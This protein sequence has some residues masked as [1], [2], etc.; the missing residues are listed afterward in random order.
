MSAL[1]PASWMPEIAALSLASSEYPSLPG[2]PPTLPRSSTAP[3]RNACQGFQLQTL[4]HWA[5]RVAGGRG[6]G[7]YPEQRQQAVGIGSWQRRAG[8]CLPG[9]AAA[10]PTCSHSHSMRRAQKHCSS[11]GTTLT[12]P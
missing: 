10:E 11:T 3:H 4:Y 8:D 9:G 7:Q 5:T 6:R 2:L 1:Q 12:T